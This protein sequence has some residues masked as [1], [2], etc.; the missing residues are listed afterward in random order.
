[1]ISAILD[2][3]RKFTQNSDQHDDMTMIAIKAIK[4]S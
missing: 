1:M 3:I 2:D 4:E